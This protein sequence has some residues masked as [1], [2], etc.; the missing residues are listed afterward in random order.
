MHE[1]PNPFLATV[2]LRIE[3]A[4]AGSGVHYELE[5]ELGSMPIAFFR[6]VEDTVRETLHQGIHGWEVTDCLV[7][8]THAGYVGKH[9]YGHARFSKAL[10]STGED[11]RGLTPLVV[12]GALQNAGT[13]VCEPIHHFHL[14]APADLLG[15]LLPA[16]ARLHA[17]PQSPALSGLSCTIEGEVPAAH[18]HRLRAELPALTRGEGVLEC[19]FERYEPVTGA[20]PTRPRTDRNPVDREEYLRRTRHG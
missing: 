6:A 14:E 4:E 19:V 8:M 3:P 11:Y 1:P 12:M 15:P 2:G 10:S 20:V 17:V 7:A 13:T 9:S 16:L 18:I 5:A